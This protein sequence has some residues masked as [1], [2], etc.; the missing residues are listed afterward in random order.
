[1][2]WQRLHCNDSTYLFRRDSGSTLYWCES[3]ETAPKCLYPI[4]HVLLHVVRNALF[5]VLE[6]EAV[7]QE[8]VLHLVEILVRLHVVFVLKRHFDGTGWHEIA[9]LALKR[10]APTLVHHGFFCGFRWQREAITLPITIT[11]DGWVH[12][13]NF[14][15]LASDVGSQALVD[16]CVARWYCSHHWVSCT[17]PSGVKLGFQISSVMATACLSSTEMSVASIACLAWDR[18]IDW[19]A[20]HLCQRLSK[21]WHSDVTVA[22]LV[23]MQICCVLSHCLWHASLHS[24]DWRQMLFL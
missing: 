5:A 13:L 24:H 22:R 17:I 23:H 6:F 19:A 12:R 7:R 16:G 11:C 10:P 2:N 9:A 21:S 3:V 1:M 8:Q 15:Q 14:I 4:R 18:C 20:K